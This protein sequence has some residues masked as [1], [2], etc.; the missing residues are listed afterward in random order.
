MLLLLVTAGCP[1]PP[2]LVER[3]P[4]TPFETA[5]LKVR[6][7][8]WRNYQSKFRLRV[9]SQTTKF[10]CRAIISVEGPDFIRFETFTPIGQT[11]AL[12]VFNKTGPALLVPS[13]KVIFT[14]G[15]QETLVREFL[16]V[17]LPADVFRFVLAAAIPPEQIDR[18]ESRFDAGAWRLICNGDGSYFEWHIS[19]GA[20]P[21][22]QG[23]FIRSSG[24]EGRVVYDP[25][26][27][28]LQ[29]AVPEKIRIS[30]SDWNMEILVEEL[31]PVSQFQPSV[32]NMPS[33]PGMRE[34]D[35]DTIK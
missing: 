26:V 23:A 8:F 17:T 16:G 7:D 3:P 21:A 15:R 11:A 4:I 32:F 30:S 27:A 22:L 24:F 14:A 2:G 9:D 35:L 5:K 6:S 18:I 34:V 29:E 12:Y 31:K 10:S 25:P 20:S 33:V 13:Q 1:R 28:V 19:A